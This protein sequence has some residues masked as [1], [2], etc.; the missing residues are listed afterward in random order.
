MLRLIRPGSLV[1]INFRYKTEF[2]TGKL[3]YNQLVTVMKETYRYVPREYMSLHTTY[4]LHLTTLR[5]HLLENYH[6]L[7][8]KGVMTQG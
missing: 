4:P 2:A 8:L 1:S 6:S 5:T 7:L 3:F